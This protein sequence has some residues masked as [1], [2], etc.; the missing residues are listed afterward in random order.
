[1]RPLEL[2]LRGFKSYFG[3]GAEFDFRDR[4]LVGIVGP[5]GSGKSTIL[6]A[7]AYALYG[8][9]PTVAANTKSLIHQRA[10][11]ATVSLRFTVEGQIWEAVRMLR[12]KGTGQHALYRY[13]HD[14][15]EEPVE[16]VL[17]E[18]DVNARVAELLGLEFDAFGRSV[19]LAQGRFAEFLQAR[20]SE[21]DKV[22][23]GVFGHDR[24]DAMRL[25]ARERAGSAALDIEKLTLRVERLERLRDEIGELRVQLADAEDRVQLMKKIEP[26]LRKL[27]DGFAAATKQVG[28]AEA[29]LADLAELEA[30]FPASVEAAR[31]VGDAVEAGTVRAARAEALEQARARLAAAEQRVAELRDQGEPELLE[32][33]AALIAK[34][35]PLQGAVA[36][37]AGRRRRLTARLDK[38]REEAD[39]AAARVEASTA[40]AASAEEADAEARRSLR[41]AAEALHE[42][43]HADMAAALREGLEVGE[44]CPV[45]TR[46][47]EAIPPATGGSDLDTAAEAHAAAAKA[48]DEAQEA[49]SRAAEQA[50]VAVKA[51]EAAATALAGLED[52]SVAAAKEVARAEQAVAEVEAEL[53]RLLGKGDPEELLAARRDV[54]ERASAGATEARETVDRTRTA[55]DQSIRDQQSAEK[56]LSALRVAI[57][58]LTARIGVPVDDSDD[59]PQGVGAR[60]DALRR[61]WEEAKKAAAADRQAADRQRKDITVER[62]ELLSA[63]GVGGDDFSSS[64]GEFTTRAALLKDEIARREQELKEGGGLASQLE[65]AAAAKATFDRVAADLTDARFVRFLL[66]EERTR[67]GALGSEHF[68]RLS[69]GRYLFSDDGRFDIVDQTSADAVRKAESLSGGETFLASLALALALAEMVARTGGR[70]DAFF[71]DEGFGSLDP[72]HLDLAM[73]GIEALVA[74]DGERL[75]VVVSHVPEMRYRIDDLIELD[76]DPATGD[77]RVVRG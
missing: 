8:R 48:A 45:C 72:E 46:T 16:K 56:A 24:I 55:H 70:L 23:K 44:P 30:R 49:R 33:G 3:E 40:A 66:D 4:R 7:I 60:L 67:L 69:S 22:L 75:V 34:L 47:V 26:D 62:R 77:T 42:A 5:I 25:A 53:E 52:E 73:E 63:A 29:R 11:D 37:A 43:Q 36:E 61:A 65:S 76:R 68:L 9:T 39:K 12:R 54:F 15:D 51:R 71:L 27:D 32:R 74:G 41:A 57:A 6:D 20:P 64:L 35:E 31:V 19:L 17:L 2:K 1:M 10:S 21:R 59:S 38:Q 18:G 14:G 58:D 50:A 28:E 13:A